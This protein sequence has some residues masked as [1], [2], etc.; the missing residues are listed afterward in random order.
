MFPKCSSSLSTCPGDIREVC[1]L[2]E[3]MLAVVMVWIC[4]CHLLL[5]FAFA[6]STWIRPGFFKW[7]LTVWRVAFT[8]NNISNIVEAPSR[9]N[10]YEGEGT[11][12]VLR[13]LR[14]GGMT[15][16]GSVLRSGKW[17]Q[18]GYDGSEGRKRK[19]RVTWH[20]LYRVQICRK[21]LWNTFPHMACGHKV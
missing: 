3:D 9:E 8:S 18:Q 20:S 1:F 21:T 16:V 7:F 10:T 14:V 4:H 17:S 12:R 6:F 19:Q 5:A 11:R 15:V 2:C 13:V